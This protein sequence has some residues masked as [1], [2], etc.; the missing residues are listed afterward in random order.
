MPRKFPLLPGIT[1][2]RGVTDG[3]EKRRK[4]CW[5]SDG[6]GGGGVQTEEGLALEGP[7]AVA[8]EEMGGRAGT[9][10]GR[11]QT[12]LRVPSNCSDFCSNLDA[13]ITTEWAGDSVTGP[14]G[15]YSQGVRGPLGVNSR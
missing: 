2:W 11:W 3:A 5:T 15:R 1:P 6:V 14:R 8:R 7:S 4:V 12:L 10:A 9:H 13:V